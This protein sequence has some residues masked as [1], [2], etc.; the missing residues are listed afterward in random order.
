MIHDAAARDAGHGRRSRDRVSQAYPGSTD[1]GP[2]GEG[3]RRRIDWMADQAQGPRALDARGNGGIL[4]LLLARRGIEVTAVEPDPEAVKRARELL[5]KE[6]AEVRERVELVQG[7]FSLHAPVQG[8]FD[9]VT[10]GDILEQADDPGALLDRCLEHL[11]PEGLAVITVALGSDPGEDHRRALRL[12]E[13]IHLLEPR[14]ALHLM[15]IEDGHVRFVGR[16]SEDRQASWQHMDIES[17]LS[18]TEAALM[19]SQARVRELERQA[20]VDEVAIAQNKT[21][22]SQFKKR[23]DAKSGEVRVLRHRLQA[24]HSSTSFRAGSAMVQA[25]KKPSSLFKLP[26]ELLRMYRS[27]SSGRIEA[28][29]SDDMGERY[30]HLPREL[31][32]DVSQFLAYPPLSIPESK[33]GRPRVAAILDTFTEHSLRYE[34]DLLLLS[35]ENWRSEI[36]ESRPELLFVESA[37]SGNNR[38]WRHLIVDCEKLEENPLHD[39]VQYCRSAG[40]PSVFWNKEDPAH[41]DNFIEAAREFDVVFTS[42]AD[43]VPVYR[44][45]LG[46]DRIHVLP[47]AAQPR[48]HNPSREEGWP[49]HPVCFAGKLGAEQVP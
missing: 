35:R 44:E 46:H 18:M 16:L 27:A 6:P 37:F 19:A 8:P 33:A 10:L 30:R 22:A 36:D 4:A 11:R 38:Q 2:A 20:E 48:L 3:L 25:A 21:A 5:A 13:V 23:L 31:D 15:E 42:D 45:A 9:T 14:L 1:P 43:C 40:I 32:L 49:N 26:F 29:D 47:F 24:T 17:V 39:L 12:T 41:F 7:D 28:L 34:A